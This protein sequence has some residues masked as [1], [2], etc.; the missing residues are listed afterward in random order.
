LERAL[1]SV[2][3][4]TYQH[5]E[6]LIINDG[7]TDNTLNIAGLFYDDRITIYSISNQGVAV[8]RNI[9]IANAKGK[10][11]CFLDA[12]D[13]WDINKL[14]EIEKIVRYSPN[15]GII[16]S[17]IVIVD[18]S[19]KILEYRKSQHIN[20]NGFTN[21]LEIPFLTTSDVAVKKEVINI[22]GNFNVKSFYSE[23]WD[24]WLR[25][26][27]INPIYHIPKYL[28]YYQRPD[29]GPEKRIMGANNIDKRSKAIELWHAEIK[30]IME[31]NIIDQPY[32]IRRLGL[33]GYHYHIAKN[34]FRYKQYNN[35]FRNF[36]KSIKYNPLRINTYISVVL[37]LLTMVIKNKSLNTIITK[38][39]FR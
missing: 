19:N 31:R 15:Y 32:S 22:V 38:K 2:L 35:A 26:A 24:L 1:N 8:A 11:L 18:S 23:D 9:G 7:S 14:H 29:I 5:F 33:A 36:I 37:I 28:T 27:K 25:I 30:S 12:D 4:Q 16:Y 39:Y 21:I 10:Y 17:D 13:Y 34:Y 3:S 6:I 20:G